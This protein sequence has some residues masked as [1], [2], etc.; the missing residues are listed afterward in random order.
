MVRYNISLNAFANELA[1][2]TKTAAADP[3]VVR[4]L[5]QYIRGVPPTTWGKIGLVGAG[6]AG[7]LAAQQGYKDWE[8]GRAIRKQQQQ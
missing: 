1:A 4:A 7:T 8:L 2:I 5:L 6:G 3:G